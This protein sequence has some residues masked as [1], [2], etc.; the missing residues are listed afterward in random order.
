M[1]LNVEPNTSTG[2]NPDPS[3]PPAQIKALRYAYNDASD[4]IGFSDARGCGSNYHYDTA[5]RLVAEDRSPCRADQ[6]IYSTANLTTGD[7]TE[8]FY[9][10]DSADPDNSAIAAAHPSFT[11]DASQL[12]G[13]IA[14]VASLGAK[15]V[16]RYDPLA[17]STG[18]AARLPR[19]GTAATAL[20][21]RY[22]PR[23]YVKTQTLDAADRP[24]TATTGATQPELL[25]AD[26]TS[27]LRFTY[28]KRGTLRQV[29]SSYGTLLASRVLLADGRDQ[30]FT[31]G[32]AA[33]TQRFL[34]YDTKHRVQDV[35]TYRANLALWTNP[36]AGSS[37]TPPAPTDDPAQ[38]LLLED[39][40]TI[41]DSAGNITA[42]EDHR[43]ATDWPATA[44]PV[45]R[46]FEYD[47]LY[48]L[49]RTSYLYPGATDTWKSPYAAE[50]ADSTRT[51][52]APHVSFT[53][54]PTE[55]RF[56]YDWLGNISQSTDDQQ[57]FFD[58][59]SGDRTHGTATAGPHRIVSASNRSLAPTST[60][61]GD[62]SVGYDEAGNVT[63]LIVRR[64]GT[65]L[66]AGASCWQR[67]AYEW[68]EVG[69]LSRARRW[70]L[71]TTERTN[72]G[73]L[74]Q[75]VPVR[76]ADAELRYAYDGSG[77][78]TLKSATRA[79]VQRHT[80]YV[81][82]GLELRSAD[83]NGT[84]YVQNAQTVSLR[85][86]AGPVSARIIYAPAM[87]SVSGTQ[88][89]VFLE[90][91]DHLGSGTAI[92]DLATSELVE[93]T[94]YMPYGAAETDYRPNRWQ[95]Y[96]EPYKFTDKEEDIEVGLAYFGARYYSPYLGVWLSTDPV[97]IHD[98]RSDPNPYAYV[99]GTPLM[100]VDRDGRFIP[101][102]VAAVIVAAVVSAG[103]NAA[104]QA[105][106]TGSWSQVDWGLSGVAGAALS[107]AAAAAVSGGVG[108]L[109]AA[110]L[111]GALGATVGA[112]ATGAIAGAAG[113]FVGYSTAVGASQFGKNKMSWDGNAALR[114]TGTGAV[115]A[116]L[117]ALGGQA[118][119]SSGFGKW[120]DAGAIKAF[121]E[122]WGRAAA[123]ATYAGLASA[124]STAGLAGVMGKDIDATDIM[125]A[126]ASA[127]AAAGATSAVTSSMRPAPTDRRA[128]END[129]TK[130]QKLRGTNRRGEVTS[131]SS[132]RR[133]TSQ[134]VWDEAKP[135]PTGGRLCSTCETHEAVVPPG[136]GTKDAPQDWHHSHM[137]SWTNREF[138]PDVTRPEV[139]DN[140]Q[141][142]LFLECPECNVGRGSRDDLYTPPDDD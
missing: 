14:S 57:A 19:P 44:K 22:A 60:R 111:A 72:N 15:T 61:K 136:E 63:G 27:E 54:R 95:G 58:R 140:Y 115:M 29:G 41:Y 94:T 66:P 50:N 2:F 51:Q 9:R 43:I 137:P 126:S 53:A 93:H 71:T 134:R 103:A 73:T 131:R 142:G 100:S 38:Q 83:F 107:G 45:T 46:V 1:V 117:T 135:G 79:G 87:P 128:S 116:P 7:G 108:G 122:T 48:R 31:L 18:V 90:L 82:A 62:L 99:H 68:D 16:Y 70:D 86:G 11:I 77:D 28:S 138:P 26:G 64:D 102:L 4:L 98:Q 3:T 20:A 12:W 84:D 106:Q 96:R 125:I 129:P 109:I 42:I 74:A 120:F 8:V 24:K 35:Q 81:F 141:E 112:V 5:G 130:V 92:I 88:Q 124:V 67:F 34:T 37:Y 133:G 39:T 17:R 123:D 85:I 21:S 56:Q 65:C 6:A 40:H 121:G 101:L 132:Y 23:W 118:L 139:I 105:S 32:D 36:P 113:S 91:A 13:R 59:S 78:R 52:P 114:A 119:A 76:A 30:S 104:M 33:A 110:P 75:P 89:H 55:Q 47:D 97:T 25:G 10:H 127:A 80:V 49:T 69:Q